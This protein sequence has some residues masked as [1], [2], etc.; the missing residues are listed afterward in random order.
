VIQRT[1]PTLSRL[2]RGRLSK[3]RVVDVRAPLDRYGNAVD[4][5]RR[6]GILRLA[7]QAAEPEWFK[8]F[9]D[10]LGGSMTVDDAKRYIEFENDASV[11]RSYEPEMIPGLLQVRGYAEAVTD[12]F[13]PGRS[14]AE[15]ERFVALRLARQQVLERPHDP[16]VF[17]AV[18]GEL[19]LRRQVADE[20]IMRDQIQALLDLSTGS[21]VT[22]R[23]A[24]IELG[25]PAA[26]GGLV[27]D[28]ADPDENG[29]VYLESRGA[30]QF[31]Q[32]DDTLDTF[33]QLHD[34]LVDAVLSVEKSRNFLEVL[35]K[36]S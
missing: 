33:R 15:R 21:N 26:I 27:M 20:T 11:I 31:L 35:A 5:A 28:L 10:V 29:V 8:K 22:V 19:A 14:A 6:D 16:L 2:E 7:G 24:P 23:I 25:H 12:A 3:P 13:F 18:I 32:D 4:P 36:A 30:P 1:A 17:D 9:S 34:D